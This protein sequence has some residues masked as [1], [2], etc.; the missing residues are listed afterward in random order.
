MEEE[1]KGIVKKYKDKMIIINNVPYYICYWGHIKTD[2]Q[3]RV[4]IS[5]L[6]KKAHD[7]GLSE[8]DFTA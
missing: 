4:T 7:E 3:T 1:V 6:L 2:R 8:I 5:E